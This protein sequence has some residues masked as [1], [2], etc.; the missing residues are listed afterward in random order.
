MELLL[1]LRSFN[2]LNCVL[3][4][5]LVLFFL[6]LYYCILR[7]TV[8]LFLSNFSQ[9]FDPM[10]KFISFHSLLSIKGAVLDIFSGCFPIF[11][12]LSA[13]FTTY[14]NPYRLHIQHMAKSAKGS[15]RHGKADN[16]IIASHS[17]V[18]CAGRT[19]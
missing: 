11:L 15:R 6:F 8:L 17:A 14:L 19:N 3:K 1:E 5:M 12:W 7:A 13:V 16:K 2:V 10:G 18:S 4:C 9:F